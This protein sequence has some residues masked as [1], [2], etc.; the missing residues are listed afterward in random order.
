V[1]PGTLGGVGKSVAM[2]KGP[3]GFKAIVNVS[4]STLMTKE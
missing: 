2:V 3:P 4:L 1:R